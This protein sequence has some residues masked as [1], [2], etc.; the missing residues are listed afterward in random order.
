MVSNGRPLTKFIAANLYK[1]QS[2]F[3]VVGIGDQCQFCFCVKTEATTLLHRWMIL[4]LQ[5]FYVSFQ[6]MAALLQDCGILCRSTER[7]EGKK[8]QFGKRPCYKMPTCFLH[9]QMLM[10]CVSYDTLEVLY[11]SKF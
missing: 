1:L 8:E 3:L 4:S 9:L 6:V 7:T 5:L 11:R 2:E 10:N